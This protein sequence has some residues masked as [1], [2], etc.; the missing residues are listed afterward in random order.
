VKLKH[1]LLLVE[2][3]EVLS[4]AL[5]LVLLDEDSDFDAF[6]EDL[7]G[8]ELLV[9]DLEG[10]D[11]FVVVSLDLLTVVLFLAGAGFVAALSD[12]VVAACLRET[13]EF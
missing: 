3:D 11:D 5:V 2:P 12:D 8:A 9:V 7:A 10:A 4:F 1:Y 13:V 6:V